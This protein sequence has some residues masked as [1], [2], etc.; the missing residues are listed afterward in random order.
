[1]VI[2]FPLFLDDE[3]EMKV[4]EKEYLFK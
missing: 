1:M 4:W 2:I 3:Y